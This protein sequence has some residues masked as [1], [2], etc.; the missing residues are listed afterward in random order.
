MILYKINIINIIIKSTLLTKY[1]F[2]VFG[3]KNEKKVIIGEKLRK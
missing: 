1:T 3:L 2:V